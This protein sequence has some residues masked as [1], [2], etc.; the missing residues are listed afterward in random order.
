MKKIPL[1]LDCDP[2]HD[3]AI[4]IL[5]AL[6]S[7]KI[8]LLGITTVA[9]NQTVAKTTNNALK[10]LELV[11]RADIPVV[12]GREN[13]LFGKVIV[14]DSVH[15]D[16]GLDGPI[17]PE[18]T[19]KALK[20][21]ACDFIADCIKKSEEKVVI[22]AIGPFTNIASFIL[23]YPEL[24]DRIQY[25]TLMGGG[26][27]EGS[28]TETAEFNVWQDPEAAKIV[29]GSGVPVHLFGLDVTHKN[30]IY[31]E[32]FE[33]FH[34][35]GGVIHKF[36]GD[37]LDFYAEAYVKVR[38][39]PGCPIHDACTIAHMIEPDIYTGEEVFLDCEIDSVVSRGSCIVDL[40]PLGRRIKPL[41]AKV[42]FDVDRE[43]FLKLLLELCDVLE[44]DLK[45]KGN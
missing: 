15:G 17:L 1:I 27:Y 25:F 9:G 5:M 41:N 19:Q 36:I 6:A 16:T 32:E 37:L 13:P 8:D 45:E 7:D 28:R 10:I 21:N 26:I 18:P 30:I 33:I 38:K 2:G 24:L 42:Y 40:R 29:F 31:S 39:F 14:A 12:A 22:A 23:A 34:K 35:H 44:A 43:K 20:M 11:K 3:D 4:A